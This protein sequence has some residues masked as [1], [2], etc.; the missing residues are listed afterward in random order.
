MY[1]HIISLAE[2]NST[3][4]DDLLV[5]ASY[6]KNRRAR[7]IH[8]KVFAGK[9]LAM[10]FEKP[11]LR[12][13][14][15]FEMAMV[16]LGGHAM[17][18]RGEEIG[19]NT[20][21][22]VKDVARVLSR[23]VQGIMIRTFAHQ[24]V[25]DLAKHAT[26]PVING[27]SDA[28]HPCQALADALTMREH[29]GPDLKGLKVVFVGDGNNVSRS[30]ARICAH[31]GARFVLAAPKAYQFT[32]ADRED[33]GV[34]W[35]AFHNQTMT[36]D[37]ELFQHLRFERSDREL[38]EASAKTIAIMR[39]SPYQKTGNAGLFLKALHSRSSAFPRLL[40]ANMGNQLA[41]EKALARLAE[42]TAAAPDLEEDKIEQIA[43]LPLGS[44]IRL[45]AAT[46]RI[47]LTATKPLALLSP[48]EKMPFEVTPFVTYL[49]RAAE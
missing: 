29:F 44:R 49:V 28:S 24:N 47:S 22:P 23:M 42:F 31:L 38:D 11:S 12:T 33:F 39:A 16:E 43:A 14:L 27:L 13:R 30:L 32:D 9:S 18:I 7:G 40:L 4:V 26:I 34:S 5:V 45:D 19:L 25:V 48:R 10:L 36:T 6:L 8:E 15:S 21:E 20:R 2:L 37:A 35:G 17:Y 3:D 41:N 46:G 1:Q